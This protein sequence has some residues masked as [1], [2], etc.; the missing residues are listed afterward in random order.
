MLELSFALAS[1]EGSLLTA[2]GSLSVSSLIFENL[3]ESL[4]GCKQ[5]WRFRASA[6]S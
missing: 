3:R 5:A 2:L 1:Q 6:K 4:G